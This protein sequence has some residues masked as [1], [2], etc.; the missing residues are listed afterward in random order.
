VDPSKLKSELGELNLILQAESN[1]AAFDAAVRVITLAYFSGQADNPTEIKRRWGNPFRKEKQTS[2]IINIDDE[3][4]A[5]ARMGATAEVATLL[6]RGA[7]I[8]ALEDLALREAVIH[9]RTS[10]VELLLDRDA[11]MHALEDEAL[12]LA[13]V[14]GQTDMVRLLLARGADP[15]VHGNGALRRAIMY[16]RPEIIEILKTHI[17]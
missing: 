12:R 6:D 2:D 16:K 9:G 17:R 15:S 11:N 13:A 14:Y 3:L 10:T 1:N 7:N 4:V 5:A 8:H